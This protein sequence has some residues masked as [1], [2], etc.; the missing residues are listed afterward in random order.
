MTDRELEHVCEVCGTVAIMTS[1]AAFAAGWDHPPR[2]G[3]WRVVSPRK[4]G[5][6]GI[7]ATLWWAIQTGELDGSDPMS[8][9]EHRRQTLARILNEPPIGYE[10]KDTNDE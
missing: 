8:W 4:C 2:M 3:V 9:P 10:R 6:C 1:A 7:D 5:N